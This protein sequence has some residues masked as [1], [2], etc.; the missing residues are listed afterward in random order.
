MGTLHK[1]YHRAVQIPLDNVVAFWQELKA[2]ENNLNRFTAK[3]FM[4]DLASAHV[5]A[6]ISPCK[7]VAYTVALYPPVPPSL[8][9]PATDQLG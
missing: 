7:L 1:V 5:Q 6:C 2:F 3:T 8:V 4:S 9:L